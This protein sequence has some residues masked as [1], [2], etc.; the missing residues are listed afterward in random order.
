[1]HA[2]LY[3]LKY[4]APISSQSSRFFIGKVLLSDLSHLC[5]LTSSLLGLTFVS[6]F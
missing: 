5:C 3:D 6:P 1:M 4:R 2:F